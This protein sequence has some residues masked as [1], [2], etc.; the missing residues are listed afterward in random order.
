MFDHFAPPPVTATEPLAT[1]LD[2]TL[3]DGGFE[4][5]FHWPDNHFGMVAATGHATGID[6]VELGYL[7]GVPLEHSVARAGVGAYLTPQH[8]AAARRDGLGLAAMVHPSALTEPVDL[9]P[10]VEA[11]LTMLRFVYHPRWADAIRAGALDARRHGLAV[12]VNIALASRYSATELVDHATTIVE[13]I[14]PDVVYIAD[15]CSALLPDQVGELVHR[16]RAAVDTDIGFHA[17]DFL[18]L[19]YANALAAV[20][21]GATYLDCSLLGLGRGGGNLAAEPLL[22][23]HRLADADPAAGALLLDCRTQL[24]ATTGRRAESLVP[25]VCAVLNLTPVEEAAV[26]EFAAAEHISD[27][28]AA[29][30]LLTQASAVATLRPQDLRAHWHHHGLVVNR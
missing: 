22:L 17:H 7:G 9:A 13:D 5:D 1:L 23:R 10:Y 4:V 21:A 19:A 14:A 20:E 24:A 11:G 15:T 12:A 8:V 26:R 27:D 29:L 18:H 16:L 25:A 3:R 28:T 30:W 2:V 6:I